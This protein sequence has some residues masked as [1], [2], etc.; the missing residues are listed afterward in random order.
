MQYLCPNLMNIIN[1]FNFISCAVASVIVKEPKVRHRA[2]IYEKFINL[3]EVWTIHPTPVCLGKRL[4]TITPQHLRS[5]NS[6]NLLVAVV[7]GLNNSG[8]GRLKWTK[9]RVSSRALEM[10][11]ELETLTSMQQSYKNYRMTVAAAEPPLIPYL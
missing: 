1:H 7:S 3:A 9:A 4:T 11:D 5:M 8:V 6:F 2:K 10:L